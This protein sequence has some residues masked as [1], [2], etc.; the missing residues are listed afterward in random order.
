MHVIEVALEFQIMDPDIFEDRPENRRAFSISN[1]QLVSEVLGD[2]VA[3]ATSSKKQ[4]LPLDHPT[5]DVDVERHK[6][7]TNRALL[8][9]PVSIFFG[10][11]IGIYS[12]VFTELL[13]HQARGSERLLSKFYF[14]KV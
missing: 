5:G 9:V 14:A 11:A 7:W 13:K 10:F 3:A 2:A 6:I 1:E 4:P 12:P 8:V